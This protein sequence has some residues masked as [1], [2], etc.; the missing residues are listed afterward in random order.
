MQPDLRK[1]ICEHI[2]RV[3]HQKDLNQKQHI[4]VKHDFVNRMDEIIPC[5]RNGHNHSR[6][7]KRN[8][9]E[10]T[11]TDSNIILLQLRNNCQS[12]ESR[13]SLTFSADSETLQLPSCY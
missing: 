6:L 12:L 7:A 5:D 2:I 4:C 11:G 13:A 8:E 1:L 9:K 10:T 3:L